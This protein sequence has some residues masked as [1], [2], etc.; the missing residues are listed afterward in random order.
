ML[1]KHYEKMAFPMYVPLAYSKQKLSP[2][3]NVYLKGIHNRS[4]NF[5]SN[6]MFI[7]SISLNL[8]RHIN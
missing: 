3:T 7:C 5:P 6:F 1:C 4:R 8:Q 2:T